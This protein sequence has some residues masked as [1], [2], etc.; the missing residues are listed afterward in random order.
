M[1]ILHTEMLVWHQDAVRRH[2]ERMEALQERLTA[3]HDKLLVALAQGIV[4]VKEVLD[5]VHV[6]RLAIE[7]EA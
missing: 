1:Q 3:I 2:A 5:D 7:K 4:G 6:I